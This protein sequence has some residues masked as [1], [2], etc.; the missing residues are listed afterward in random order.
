MSLFNAL[1]PHSCA[2]K[3]TFWSVIDPKI[4][5]GQARLTW[6]FFRRRLLKRKMH[7][8]GMSTILI[9]LSLGPG[10]HHPPR[11][12]YHNPPPLEDR[13]PRRSIPSQEPS[14]LATY[15]CLV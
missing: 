2:P 1:C 13:R 10:Y 7:L 15:V 5:L 4:S 12:G 9:L 11:P 8:I 3:K 6:M 14:L